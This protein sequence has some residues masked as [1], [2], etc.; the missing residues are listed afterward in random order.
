[1]LSVG[2]LFL[3][4][5]VLLFL[6]TLVDLALDLFLCFVIPCLDVNKMFIIINLGLSI[7]ICHPPTPVDED[8]S[9]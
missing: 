9:K 2:L 4:L 3:L 6:I 7:C 8:Y 5:F 1:M